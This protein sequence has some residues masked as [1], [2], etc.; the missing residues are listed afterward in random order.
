MAI[1][2]LQRAQID[3][4]KWNN[5]I[6]TSPQSILYAN[7]WYL[8]TITPDW[9]ALVMEEN[10]QWQAVMPLPVRQ[11]W[12][13]KVIQ[14]PLFCQML[15]V[16]SI[17]ETVFRQATHAFLQKLP[18]YFRYISIYTGRFFIQ[19]GLPN[20]YEIEHCHTHIL[21][22]HLCYDTLYENY[23]ADRR[24]NLHRAKKMNWQIEKSGDINPLIALFKTYHAAQIEGGVAES[25]YQLLQ[26]VAK[27]LEEKKAMHLVY[28]LKDGKIEAGALF[29]MDRQRIIYLFNAA[30]PLGR[31]GNARSL[32]IDQIIQ[33]Y[34]ETGI[35]FD[36][37]SP[38]VES[39]ASFYQSFGTKN[40]GYQSLHLNNLPFPLKQIQQW[41]RK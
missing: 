18:A 39:I 7:T 25:A 13:T 15:G 38:E 10:G 19:D 5:F 35:I 21:P 9:C 30:S 17:N 27:A 23:T 34:A 16:F 28:A 3:T 4:E 1:F 29:A 32:L 26:K 24:L 22:L 40:E 33:Q 37:E 11:K 12:R 6:A 14:Q 41:R 20:N 2:F 36:F 8:D 31:K